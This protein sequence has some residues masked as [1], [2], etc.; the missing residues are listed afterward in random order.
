MLL[1]GLLL[2]GFVSLRPWKSLGTPGLLL[3]YMEG[4]PIGNQERPTGVHNLYLMLFG[5]AGIIPPALYLLALFFLMRLLWTVPKSL[6]RDVVVG[7]VLV[8]ALFS[9]AFHHL[10]TMGA[11]NF[12]IGLTCAT[13]TFLAHKQT[14]PTE[15]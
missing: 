1:C 14:A 15:E 8:M 3:H 6:G 5:E 7:W 2:M 12:A 10:L 4:A 9:L 13:A 11:Y